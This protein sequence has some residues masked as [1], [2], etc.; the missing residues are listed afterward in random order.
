MPPL[1][2]A[3]SVPSRI[4][5][6]STPSR[7]FRV[8][9]RACR[10]CCRPDRA[11]GRD[12]R[13]GPDAGAPPRR[14]CPGAADPAG[15]PAR[16]RVAGDERAL[17]LRDAV[18]A[19]PAA[20]SCARRPRSRRRYARDADRRRA[21]CA[22]RPLAGHHD[23]ARD[24]RAGRRTGAYRQSRA[25]LTAGSGS[26][27]RGLSYLPSAGP[28]MPV[29]GQLGNLEEAVRLTTISQID[30]GD[31][32][33]GQI[34]IGT[35]DHRDAVT[36]CQL[37]LLHDAEV[38][39]RTSGRG[40]APREAGIVHA[41]PQL[42]AGKARLRNLEQDR[43][44]APA[45]AHNRAGDGHAAHGQVLAKRA[46]LQG[47][48]HLSRPPVVVLDGISVYR[49]VDS[50]VDRAIRLIVT[51]EI[52]TPDGHPTGDR[53]LPDAAGYTLAVPLD[54]ARG[55]N[56]DRLDNAAMQAGSEMSR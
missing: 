50:A 8:R 51:H 47:T 7:R 1:I 21:S 32:G 46:R 19:V 28:G 6:A 14:Q 35:M 49:L 45:L 23:R 55:T 26:P 31:A 2:S 15:P 12:Q 30:V 27:A 13:R 38:R 20:G 10:H 52:H 17:L 54:D 34:V 33:D 43:A 41:H 29:L 44:D 53:R 25:A 36:G 16:F 5:S 56:V 24:R 3:S 4:S 40:K 18:C 37:A 48:T 42:V 9:D 11:G 22:A 39:A